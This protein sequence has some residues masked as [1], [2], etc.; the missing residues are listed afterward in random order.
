MLQ[1]EISHFPKN[2]QEKQNASLVSLLR[3]TIKSTKI[4]DLR[5]NQLSPSVTDFL[6]ICSNLQKRSSQYSI[7]T[8]SGNRK[9]SSQY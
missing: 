5:G 3:R 7:W 1:T 2:A 9:I 6:H 4:E 8:I